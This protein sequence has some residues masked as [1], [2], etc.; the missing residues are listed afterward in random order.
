VSLQTPDAATFELRGSRGL[1]FDEYRARLVDVVRAHLA[2]PGR[3]QLS[4]GFLANPLR[5]FRAPGAPPFRVAESGRAL[6]AQLAGWVEWLFR[7]TAQEADIPRLLGRTRRA[8]I[9]K[10]SRI[11]LTPGLDFQVRALGS[12]AEHFQRPVR[13]ARF[14]YC[15]ALQEQLG[16]LWTGDYVICCADY[17]GRT[18]LASAVDTP[19]RD[20]LALPAVQA[21]A[22]GFRRYRVV[23]PYCRRCL[24]DRRRVDVLARGI[25]SILY[26][27]WYRPWMAARGDEV[28]AA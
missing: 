22:A 19:L 25:G 6:R 18:A 4:I 9:L 27:R 24:G 17:D 20:Y 14:G 1:P 10:E 12:W 7:G 16:I 13:P 5:R 28:G 8:G 2:D 23:H 21:I 15:P 3:L 11:R 26:F